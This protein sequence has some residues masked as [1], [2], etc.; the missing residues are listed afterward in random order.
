MIKENK[1]HFIRNLIKCFLLI[2]LTSLFISVIITGTNGG[3][4]MKKLRVYSGLLTLLT[5]VSLSSCKRIDESIEHNYETKGSIASESLETKKEIETVLD[6]E[7]ILETTQST[8]N[9]TSKFEEKKPIVNKESITIS[10]TGDCTLGTYLTSQNKAFDVLFDKQQDYAYYFQNVKNIFEND[11]YTVVN[12]EGPLTDST[13]IN[14]QKPFI[15]K[16]R[17]DYINI[18]TSG[19]VEAANL[20]NNHIR[21]YGNEGYND[22][23]NVLKENNI[24]YFDNV[25]FHIEDING[26]KFGFAGFKAFNLYT[27][28]EIDKALEYFEENNVDIKI[29]TLH[30]GI[31]YDYD[32]DTIKQELAHYAIDNGA[33]LIVGHHPHILQGV[34][35]YNDKYILY[36]LGNFCYGGHSNPN[37]KNSM[38]AQVTFNF[39]D[40]KYIDSNL[41]LIPVS[42]SSVDYTNN[43]QPTVLE[44]EEKEKVLKLIN[45]HSKNFNYVD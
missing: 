22:T 28:N 25:N 19:G 6:A 41:K 24:A 17:L 44:G 16:G 35:E 33:D 21:D 42:I 23:V 3:Y 13:N 4:Y 26:I 1:E 5:T 27:K 40:N 9:I 10:F 43:F 39:E 34:E 18:L 32:F 12:L 15:F 2:T 8:S 37:D 20:S 29:I 14:E 36:S 45:D 38:I 7:T 30:G 31:E 11:D